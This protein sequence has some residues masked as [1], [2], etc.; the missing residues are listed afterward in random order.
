MVVVLVSETKMSKRGLIDFIVQ[1]LSAII[2]GIY[3]IHLTIVFSLNGDM[4]YE[5]WKS[6]FSSG[7]A[8]IL[9]TLAVLSIVLH[10]WIGMWTVGTDYIRGQALGNAGNG[11]R[12]AYQFLL[13][14]LLIA[15]LIWVL[16][17]IWGL[18]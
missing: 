18:L 14:A 7:Y 6:Y 13:A 10:A 3:A 17:L 5:A 9:S 1:R 15:Y 11:I 2:I 12:I 4:D 8:L 16:M